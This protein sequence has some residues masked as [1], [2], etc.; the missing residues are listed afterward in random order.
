M[1]VNDFELISEKKALINHFYNNLPLVV[2]NIE[3]LSY[4][5]KLIY[6]FLDYS[7]NEDSENIWE[8]FPQEGM[9]LLNQ[10]SPK[11]RISQLEAK[12]FILNNRNVIVSFI[13]PTKE[14]RDLAKEIIGLENF[15][16][17]YVNAPIELCERRD[18]KG[19][20][21]KVRAG[22]IKDFTG[23]DSPYEAPEDP[24][25]ELRTDI[26]SIEDSAEEILDLIIDIS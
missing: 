21:K 8:G 2:E 20:Y 11:N 13:S 12:L 18:V 5:G 25:L 7:A 3:K 16:E 10:L 24:D 1:D 23:I 22:K 9:N 4:E 14:I 26:L 15:I 17:I 6:K 19:L